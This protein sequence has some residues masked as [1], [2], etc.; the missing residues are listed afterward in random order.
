M[1]SKQSQAIYRADLFRHLDGIVT[2]PS[3]YALFEKG[4]TDYIL[5]NK[6]VALS[7][8][9]EK[10]SA[11][12]GYLN[13][14]LRVLCS[15]G[16]LEQE[17]DNERDCV[18]YAVNGNSEAAFSKFYLYEDVV[19]W[20]RF[21]ANYDSRKFEMEPFI[22]LEKV[23]L[24]LKNN[25]GIISSEVEGSKI[26]QQILKHIEGV[27][28]GPTAVYLGMSGMFHKYFMQASFKPEEFHADSKSFGR[29]L[30]FFVDFGWF[31]KDNGTYRFTEKGLFYARRSAAYGVT[32]S[33]I[34][35]LRKLD[36]LI[37][38]N[39]KAAK[40]AGDGK[41]EGHVDRQM[42]VWGS[43]GAHAAYF[44]V[45]D[46]IIIELF[47]KPIAEQPQGILDMGC[48]NGAFLQHLFGVIEQKTERGK[49]LDEYPLA[50][51]GVDYNEEALKITKANLIQADIW[52]KVI[53]GDIGRP[54][55]LAKELA[56]SY[57]IDLKELLNVR[58]F[59]DHN[60]IWK[61]PKVSDSSSGSQRVSKSTGAFAFEGKRINNNAVEESL[62]EH[63]TN[64][65]PYIKKF[66]LLVIELHTV[67][68]KL[69]AENLGRTAATAYDATHG[70]SDQYIV[71]VDVF[72]KVMAEV[73]LIPDNN[74]C[75]KFPDSDIA[76]VTV[77]LF[78]KESG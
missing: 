1:I 77:N 75:K 55:L 46:Q 70:Y 64:W 68:P 19:R 3:A 48:G 63:L 42:N 76:T 47:N 15:Q 21:S 31:E 62:L 37:F 53:W 34:P 73:G 57:K 59:L 10:F 58:T 23:F 54:D 28:V 67:D 38:G 5:Q 6:E 18:H 43:G 13:V 60:R 7:E 41:S 22:V 27:I 65:E 11:N 69:V 35:T 8:L 36:E 51:V 74:I 14:A 61:E 72:N 20:L 56:D 33:Y 66:G 24:K 2:A 52:A 49:L 40:A 44:K 26:I 78:R 9:T 32:V 50:L 25:F 39:P 30:D 16:W 4:V 12:E 45:V 17:I 71:E 29:L